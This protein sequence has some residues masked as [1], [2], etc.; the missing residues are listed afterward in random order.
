MTGTYQRHKTR[1]GGILLNLEKRMTDKQYER[2]TM[3]TAMRVGREG[4]ITRGI[5]MQLVQL[6]NRS[7]FGRMKWLFF[8]R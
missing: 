6:L 8:K 5:T 2:R 3:K 4:A 7:F 1:A